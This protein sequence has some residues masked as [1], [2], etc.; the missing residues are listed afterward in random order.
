MIRRLVVKISSFLQK[1]F[2]DVFP[3]MQISIFMVDC[4]QNKFIGAKSLIRQHRGR[5]WLGTEQV[6]A[7]IWII[8]TKLYDDSLSFAI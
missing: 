5:Q 8:L 2:I 4:Y 3:Q 6:P 7:I 1:M